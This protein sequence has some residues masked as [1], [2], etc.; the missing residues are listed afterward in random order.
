MIT[1]AW[2]F[3]TLF[4]FCFHF[5]TN[6]QRFHSNYS[7]QKLKFFLQILCIC[8]PNDKIHFLYELDFKV[9][10]NENFSFLFLPKFLNKYS[11]KISQQLFIPDGWNFNTLFFF[12]MPYGGLNSVFL[13]FTNFISTFCKLSCW[14]ACCPR[15]NNSQHQTIIVEDPLI[16]LQLYRVN[17]SLSWKRAQHEFEGMKYLILKY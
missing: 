15:K 10:L 6:C 17:Q 4:I 1:E 14:I 12:G 11:S 9:L 8:M 7:L 3:K 5:Q 13:F 2:F 16:K